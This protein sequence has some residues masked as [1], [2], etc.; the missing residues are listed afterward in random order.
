MRRGPKT[1]QRDISEYL[2]RVSPVARQP[3]P[4]VAAATFSSLFLFALLALQP[5]WQLFLLEAASPP[6]P[7]PPRPPTLFR[8][9]SSHGSFAPHTNDI[10]THHRHRPPLSPVLSPRVRG[11]PQPLP[12]RP[13][14][15]T[16]EPQP[17]TSPTSPTSSTSPS[18]Q[19]S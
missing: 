14:W 6:S 7:P 13:R 19:D 1:V 18:C 4:L 3:T 16:S 8:N 11:I 9:P 10:V 15:G 2:G 17:A 5:L 12:Q